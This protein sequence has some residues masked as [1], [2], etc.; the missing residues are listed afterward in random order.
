MDLISLIPS[1]GG[2]LYTVGAFVVALSV[3]VAVHE[4]G[5]YIVGRWSGIHA[6]VFSLGFGPVLF[7]RRD[8][9]GT[10]WQVALLPLGGYVKFAG[11]ANAASVGEADT[12]GLDAQERRRTMHGAPLW[13]RAATVAAGPVF[14]FILSIVVFS[15]VMMIRGVPSDPL[16]VDDIIAL[17][18]Q[19]QELRPGDEILSIAGREAPDLDGFGAFVDA[20]PKEPVLDY[21]VLRG[22]QRVTVSAPY[23]MPAAVGGVTPQS[24]AADV[25]MRI[26]D[27]ITAVD[28]APIFA[29]DQLRE[30]VAAADGATMELDV[31]RSGPGDGARE[32]FVLAPRRVDL[33]AAD[34]GFETRWLIGITGG[35]LFE[36]RTA[37]PGPLEAIGYGAEQTV[38]IVRSSLSGLY[39]M[40]AGLISSCN[41]RGPIGIAQTSGAAASQGWISFVWFI[42]VLSTA[43]GLLNL[44]PIPVLDGGHLVF[45][46]Y[47][48]VTGR[49]PSERALNVLM[50]I[51]LALLGTLMI[52]ALTNDLFCP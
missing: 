38:F 18:P 24:A 25:D 27:V 32:T 52:F 20:L 48:A 46:G 9:R 23:P 31:W 7:S 37:M 49:P 19:V 51:G 26:G 50:A 6:E 43:V 44:F 17:P 28:G 47:E 12:P 30:K 1:F 8:R 3:I 21:E 42:A 15:A 16:T 22:D 5:H 36:P 34:G 11:D 33:P 14:N 10:L 29:F 45:H 40:A 39:H 4:Y 13:A 35:L 41:L 2:F